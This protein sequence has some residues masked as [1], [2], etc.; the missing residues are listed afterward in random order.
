MKLLYATKNS[1]KIYN[2]KTRLKDLP[3]ELITPKDLNLNLN[4]IEDGKSTTENALKKAR[5]YYQATNIPT[6]AGDTILIISKLPINK[7]PGLYVRRINGKELTDDEMLNYYLE[8]LNSIGGKSDAYYTTSLALI[9]KSGVF[10]TEIKEDRRILTNKIKR[11]ED[12]YKDP[13]DVISIDP[14]T[15]KYFTELTTSELTNNLTFSI[16]CIEFI[17][18]NF[19]YMK[20]Q[21]YR[22]TITEDE[23]Y[24]RQKSTLVDFTT[25]DITDDLKTLDYFCNHDNNIMAMAAVQLGIPKRII[26]LK[27]TDLERL[28]EDY[29]E[30]TIL[31]NPKIIKSSGLTT[32]WEACA[33]CN[34]YTGLVKRPF[35]IDLEYY[36]IQGQKHQ[37]I[38][39]GFKATVLSHEL[40]HLDGILHID[41]A[42]D[43]QVMTTEERK[44][45]RKKHPYNIIR[46]EGEY[47]HPLKNK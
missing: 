42:E 8:L 44:E 21:L 19:T 26:Y 22:K 28:D 41:I 20:E 18:E 45:F 29:N 25:D 14:Y 6:I 7:Q 46:K 13:L 34:D 43:L 4:I 11:T 38:F 33:S 10:T 35:K 39:E 32:F 47:I 23:P 15:G 40:D 37:E 9:T 36:D 1:A 5:A 24:L 31:I 12:K 3:I 16:K 27:K 2:M 30:S 17:K